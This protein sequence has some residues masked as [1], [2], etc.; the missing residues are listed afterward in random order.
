MHKLALYRITL[1]V[2]E[3]YKITWKLNNLPVQSKLIEA[4]NATAYLLD[5]KDINFAKPIPKKQLFHHQILIIHITGNEHI[6]GL[7]YK[8]QVSAG[9]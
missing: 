6:D 9:F 2:G 5:I 3:D 7:V 4:K 8:I 1:P